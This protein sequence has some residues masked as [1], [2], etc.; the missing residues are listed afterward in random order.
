MHP[1]VN[2]QS[3]THSD[4]KNQ[5]KYTYY[6]SYIIRITKEIIKKLKYK[7]K[8]QIHIKKDHWLIF[9]SYRKWTDHCGLQKGFFFTIKMQPTPN[10]N[11]GPWGAFGYFLENTRALQMLLRKFIIVKQKSIFV[12]KFFVEHS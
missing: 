7:I 9:F 5:L 4:Q 10:Y 2:I 6:F 11:M 3:A 1:L 12:G 8:L